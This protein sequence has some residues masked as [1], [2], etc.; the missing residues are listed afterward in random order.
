LKKKENS[1]G[2]TEKTNEDDSSLPLPPHPY[3]EILNFE[4]V[5]CVVPL[6]I[7][8]ARETLEI[9]TSRLNYFKKIS[10]PEK[11]IENVSNGKNSLAELV[12]NTSKIAWGD[13]DE[14]EK[15]D[16]E[17][18]S[19]NDEENFSEPAVSNEK[20]SKILGI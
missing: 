9:V 20:K 16:A 18:I 2:E 1:D 8:N 10:M 7:G 4:H 11:E 3:S 12:E 5:S 6:T 14:D 19:E 15:D 13:E 17:K